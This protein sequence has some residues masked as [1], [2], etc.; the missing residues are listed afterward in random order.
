MRAHH[1]EVGDTGE[2]N[3]MSR[4]EVTVY[5]EVLTRVA[6]GL[7]YLQVENAVLSFSVRLP[8]TWVHVGFLS[9]L[10]GWT[11]KILTVPSHSGV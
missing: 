10:A 7:S 5:M 8:G 3:G 6:R 4:R 9:R 2:Q 1:Q 11:S